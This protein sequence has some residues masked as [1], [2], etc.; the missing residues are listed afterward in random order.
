M[1]P[2]SKDEHPLSAETVASP[3]EARADPFAGAPVKGPTA[4]AMP[5]RMDRYRITA[6]LGSGGFGIVYL[7]YDDDLKRPVAI[8]VPHRHRIVSP[9]DVEHYLA[10]ARTLASLDHAGIV[11]VYDV[12]RTDDGLCFVV[13]KFVEGSD[14]RARL[15]QG[16]LPCQD[17]AL[18]VA[19]VAEALHHAHQRGLVHRDIKPANI[20]LDIV[21]RPIVA[22]FGLALREEDFGKGPALAGTPRYMSPEQARGE[23]HRVDARS[24][25][26]SLGV[27]LYEL[28]TGQRPFEAAHDTE[29]LEQIQGQEARPP[30]QLDDSI[31][32]ELDRICLKALAT[33]ASDRYSTALDLAEDLRHWLVGVNPT[34]R[35][36]AVAMSPL[37]AVEATRSARGVAP[38]DTGRPP[39]LIV[40]KGL[41]SFDA[42][43]ADFFVEL[44]PGPRDRD[45]LPDSV[46]FWKQRI[47]TVDPDKTFAVGLLYG[48][49]GCGKSSLVKAG[50]LPR[51]AGHVVAVY[52]EAMPEGTEQRLASAL[53]R[54]CPNL[55]AAADLVKTLALLR[56]GEGLP[57]GKKVVLVLDQFEQWLHV[58][59]GEQ[60]AAMVQ[61]LRQCDGEHVQALILVRDDFWMA[62]TRFMR[63]LE[64]PLVEGENSAAVDLFDLRHARKVLAALGRAFGT[65]PEGR[66][67]PEQEDFL[68]RAVAGLAQEGKV[69]PVRLSLFAEMVKGYAWVPTTMKE[70]GGTEGVGVTFL[71]Q[72]FSVSTAPPEHRLHEKAAR[73][74]LRAL[75]PEQGAEIKGH[76]RSHQELLAASGYAG[77]QRDFDDLLRILDG[78]LRLI[79]PSDPEGVPG[80]EW[81]VAG[82]NADDRATLTAPAPATP[83]P[84]L[85]TRFYQLTHD[86]LVPTLRQWLTR[87]QQENWRGRAELRLAERTAQWNPS[88]NPRLLPALPEFLWL[89]SGVA[90]AKRKPAERALLGAA[91]RYHALH[92]GLVLAALFVAGLAV[93]QYVASVQRASDEARAE[94]L[95][96]GVANAAPQDVPAAIEQ[97][98][99][100]GAVTLS[101]VRAHFDKAAV[102]SRQRLHLI[103]ALAALGDV[104]EEYLLE[105]IAK[106]PVSEA[107][108]TMTALARARTTVVPKLLER[109]AAEKNPDV[110]A[111]LAIV[112]LHLGDP[113]GAERVLALGP[114][115]APRTAFIHGFAAWHGNLRSLPDLL[116]GGTEAL[117]SGICAALGMVDPGNL[118]PE[119]WEALHKVVLRLYSEGQGGGVHSAAWWTLR[120]WKQELPSIQVSRAAAAGRGWFLN[121]HG[122]TMVAIQPGTFLMGDAELKDAAPQQVTLKRAYYL[123]DR[124]ITVDQFKQF[125]DDPDYAPAK[126]PVNLKDPNKGNAPTGDCAMC[127]VSWLD[128]VLF[129]NWLTARERREPCYVEEG[130]AWTCNFEA[131]GYRLPTEA[132]W[133]FACRAGTTTAYSFGNDPKALSRYAVFAANSEG[134]TWPGGSKLPNG[135]GL[136]DMHGNVAEW[137]WDWYGPADTKATTDPRG[138]AAGNQHPAR[139][140]NYVFDARLALSGSR[141]E[142]ALPNLRTLTVGF[143]VACGETPRPK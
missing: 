37:A 47:E 99:P 90:R 35:S 91:A 23:G 9:E 67:A 46:R 132:E 126:K 128:A 15:Q 89:L 41:R 98:K 109:V 52:V 82:E 92:A 36:D 141:L 137:C 136:F 1:G 65:L 75:L 108:N 29:L 117:Q 33:R 34:A 116:G 120:Q 83:N 14:L 69:V 78:E 135:W 22:D 125:L 105:R 93:Q 45:R 3:G 12:G 85:T 19:S 139:G 140:G 21:G 49:S 94:M 11:P 104:E 102:D 107:R 123:C 96:Q 88:R 97:L 6:R 130:K 48:P 31:P 72:T 42:N 87:K 59:R 2:P 76:M 40:P 7:G 122:M 124:E 143:R 64:V 58:Q 43:D 100:V 101:L 54:R 53:R 4:A 81:T 142:R 129:C 10:E 71:E 127:S 32:R 56:R 51:L 44:L 24:D 63:D 79:T 133:E 119:E 5:D 27:V 114:D 20:L 28:L 62:T 66:L 55:P 60:V 39:L 70:L 138:P 112:L 103:F 74:V 113:G 25:V 57:A 8:K 30:R 80:V 38:S 26:Y 77:R 86:Y 95:V 84:P 73:A 110:Q 115:P 106:L 118:G 17:A 131:D 50:L 121:R 111:R 16:R 18:I 61:A 68:D 13:S 134:H